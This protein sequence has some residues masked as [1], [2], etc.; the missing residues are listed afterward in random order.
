[1]RNDFCAQ[2]LSDSEVVSSRERFGRNLITPPKET[3]WWMLYLEKFR[4]PIIVILLVA[5]GISLVFGFVNGDFT[6]SVGIVCAVLIATGVG[7]WQEYSAKRKFDAMRSDSDYE[8]VKVRRGG[9]V[10]EV[11]K[12]EL[13]VGDVVVLSAGDEV[14]ADIELWRATEMKVTEACMTAPDSS[15]MSRAVSTSLIP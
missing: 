3:P 5:T 11:G 1:M 6:E 8:R 15:G 4:D 10:V 14:P 13:V 2:G 7:F 12:D 9:V